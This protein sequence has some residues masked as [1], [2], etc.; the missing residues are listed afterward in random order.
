MLETKIQ[1][2]TVHGMLLLC[3]QQARTRF[4]V[5]RSVCSLS[6]MHCCNQRGLRS[7]PLRPHSTLHSN[8]Q[9]PKTLHSL[10]V[11][12]RRNHNHGASQLQ[13]CSRVQQDCPNNNRY[14]ANCIGAKR[15]AS[16]NHHDGTF[17][18]T[19][20][21]YLQ[22]GHD[23]THPIRM[24]EALQRPQGGE[25]HSD[26]QQHHDLPQGVD[27]AIDRPNA[28]PKSAPCNHKCHCHNRS[29]SQ[30]QN[31]RQNILSHRRRGPTRNQ[32]ARSPYPS[33]DRRN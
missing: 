6:R 29:C 17:A 18:A 5:I 31:H 3:A 20:A 32:H 23:R 11:L 12:I 19:P 13:A 28:A 9:K 16:D 25:R 22:M 15:D 27:E 30:W 21:Q 24:R 8:L 1:T 2:L 10:R 26:E 33:L 14:R 4:T 7:H